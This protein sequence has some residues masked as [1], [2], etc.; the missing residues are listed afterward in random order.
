M[1]LIGLLLYIELNTGTPSST[2]IIVNVEYSI[3]SIRCFSTTTTSATQIGGS[4]FK[5]RTCK[6]EDS[7]FNHFFLS[8]KQ[9]E[10]ERETERDRSSSTSILPTFR[11]RHFAIYCLTTVFPILNNTRSTDRADTVNRENTSLI[12]KN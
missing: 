3:L 11:G 7:V 8:S 1:T 6:N 5:I 2:K 4:F 10:R 12:Q 9:W